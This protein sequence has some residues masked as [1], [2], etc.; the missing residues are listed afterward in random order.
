MQGV[1]THIPETNNV[2]KQYNV[3]LLF[4]VIIIIIAIIITLNFPCTFSTNLE[5]YITSHVS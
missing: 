5:A 2:P 3:S 1:Y 4:M